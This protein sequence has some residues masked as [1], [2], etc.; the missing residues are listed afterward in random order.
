MAKF[1]DGSGVQS[2][3]TDIIKN[4][5]RKL[6]IVSPYLKIS[7]QTKHYL[8]SIDKKNI[9]TVI[10][11][12]TGKNVND[13][14]LAFFKELS[15]LKYGQC[16]NLHSKCYL[17]EKEGLITSMNLH[18][19]SQT[20]NW[21]MGILFSKQHDAEIYRDVIKELGHLVTQAKPY[22]EVRAFCIRCGKPMDEFNPGKP[23]CNN[24]YP[25]WARYKRKQYAEKFCHACGSDRTTSHL[26]FEKPLCKD[27]AGK[28]Q[29]K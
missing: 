7:T 18:E 20:H 9:P 29:K 1:L 19:Y 15:H 2:A 27:C 22:T 6:L 21:E 17:N 28:M 13:D 8:K 5:E 23:L 12:R 25:I 10:I 24:C 26:S 4:A 14:D 11:F 3:I 16:E